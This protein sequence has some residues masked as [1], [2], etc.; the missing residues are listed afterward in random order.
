LRASRAHHERDGMPE[1]P[2]ANPADWSLAKFLVM[3][4]LSKA[5]I[6]EFL[7]LPWL[8]AGHRPSF[9][10]ASE[11][12]TL[13]AELPSGPRWRHKRIVM[14][15]A[16]NETLDLY[17]RD[18]VECLQYLEQKPAFRGHQVFAPEEQYTDAE[19]TTREYNEM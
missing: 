17:Y 3:S 12:Y 9:S 15:E 6:D 14:E 18:P 1:Y 4:G 2:F 7:K 8:G 13:I 16:P 10:S 11:L 19:M 5:K